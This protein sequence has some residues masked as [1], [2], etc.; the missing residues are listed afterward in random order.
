M[1][2]WGAVAIPRQAESLR[3]ALMNVAFVV[4]E[5]HQ[6]DQPGGIWSEIY[7]EKSTGRTQQ[8]RSIHK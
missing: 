3:V 4:F 2:G 6:N 1:G 8:L 5:R 7:S